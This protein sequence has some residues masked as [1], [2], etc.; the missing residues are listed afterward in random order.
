MDLKVMDLDY[1]DDW[2]RFEGLNWLLVDFETNNWILRMWSFL[3]GL[4]I[5]YTPGAYP[6]IF[7]GRYGRENLGGCWDVFLEKTSQIEKNSQK[8]GGG[9]GGWPPKPFSEYAP[10]I[11]YMTGA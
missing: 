7:W 3:K 8:G 1:L 11:L 9:G 2:I 10:G 4:V 5:L 6:E